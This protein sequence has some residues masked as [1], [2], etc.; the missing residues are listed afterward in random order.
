[1]FRSTAMAYIY[2]DHDFGPDD[3][4]ATHPGKEAAK[5]IYHQTFPHY[6]LHFEKISDGPLFQ[7]ITDECLFIAYVIIIL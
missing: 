2:D 6:P 1:M 5:L 3:A 4:D 7:V